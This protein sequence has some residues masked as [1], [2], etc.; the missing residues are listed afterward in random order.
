MRNSRRRRFGGKPDSVTDFWTRCQS[1]AAVGGAGTSVMKEEIKKSDVA[2]L[3]LRRGRRT[4]AF[5]SHRGVRMKPANG[6]PTGPKVY[7]HVFL[8]F[9]VSSPA[10]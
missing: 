10:P 2:A 3:W 7:T 1:V 4:V 6:R 9:T 8:S 5:L